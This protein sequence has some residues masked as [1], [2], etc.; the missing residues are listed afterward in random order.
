MKNQ[1]YRAGFI[2]AKLFRGIHLALFLDTNQF[3]IWI[4]I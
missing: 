1:I 4:D 2:Q 3:G